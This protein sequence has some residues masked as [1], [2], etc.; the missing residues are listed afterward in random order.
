VTGSPDA[1]SVRVTSFG[2]DLGGTH[3]RV[4]RFSGLRS[5]AHRLQGPRDGPDHLATAIR[6]H[7]RERVGES[8]D[9]DLVVDRIADLLESL[10]AED[11]DVVGLDAEGTPA[12]ADVRSIL[13]VGVAI[14][15]MPSGPDGLIARSPN[16]DWTD[17]PLGHLL[18]DRLPSRYR[19]RVVNDVNAATYGELRLGAG[20]GARDLLSVFVGT[21]IGGG[22]VAGG[23]LVE[24]SS[25]C[26]GEIGHSKVVLTEEARPCGCGNSGCVEA[27]AGGLLLERR[28]RAELSGGERS[29]A[30]ELAGDAGSVTA[31]HL[32][33]AAARGDPYALRLWDEVAPLLGAALANAVALLNPE[34][35]ILGGGMLTRTP[36]LRRR[37]LEAL[38]RMGVTPALEALSI[39][40]AALE[41]GAGAAGAALLTETE[42]RKRTGGPT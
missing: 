10:L 5:L 7:R 14:A 42:A 39:R 33:R 28:A 9:P 21:G 40:D 4:V 16:L 1:G 12:A 3:L 17:V 35:L 25:G 27:Y 38:E 30:V 22:V 24:G 18:R 13:P 34:R 8:R 37:A 15:G 36:L 19:I 2:V 31:A 29:L 23:E 6:S 41:D 11:P 20:V 26:A 32:D